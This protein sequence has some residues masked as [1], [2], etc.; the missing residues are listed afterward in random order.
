[1]PPIAGRSIGG[2]NQSFTP[3]FVTNGITITSPTVAISFG[4]LRRQDNCGSTVSEKI[5]LVDPA[6]LIS[7]RGDRVYFSYYPFNLDDLAYNCATGSPSSYMPDN[8]RDDCYQV[9]PADAYF[10]GTLNWINDET[11]DMDDNGD[12]REI[13]ASLRAGLTIWPDYQPQI[14]MPQTMLP[15]ITSVFASGN[16][17][18]GYYFIGAWDPP[19]TLQ[20]ASSLDGPTI[21]TAATTTSS[22]AGQMASLVATPAHSPQSV[23]GTTTGGPRA[24]SAIS[25]IVSGASQG[26][27]LSTS[28]V[29]GGSG[30][31]SLKPDDPTPIT[32]SYTNTDGVSQSSVEQSQAAQVAGSIISAIITTTGDPTD[33]SPNTADTQDPNTD[34]NGNALVITLGSRTMSA[35]RASTVAGAIVLGSNTLQVS[36][37]AQ[38]FNGQYVSAGTAGLVVGTGTSASTYAISGKDAPHVS[39]LTLDGNIIYIS[40]FTAPDVGVVIGLQTSIPS[41]AMTTGRSQPSATVDSGTSPASADA[42]ASY[43]IAG[44][45]SDVAQASFG[46]TGSGDLDLPLAAAVTIN[47]QVYTML[48]GTVAGDYFLQGPS[49]TITLHR[50]QDVTLSSQLLTLPSY[51]SEAPGSIPY[52]TGSVSSSTLDDQLTVIAL[53]GSGY[54]VQDASTT[55]VLSVGGSVATLASGEVVSAESGGVVLGSIGSQQTIVVGSEGVVF[56]GAS[57]TSDT[58]LLDYSIVRE[59]SGAYVV[60]GPGYTSTMSQGG[61]AVTLNGVGVTA[62]S[63]TLALSSGTRSQTTSATSAKKTSDTTVASSATSAGPGSSAPCSATHAGMAVALSALVTIFLASGM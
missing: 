20:M 18:C 48:S 42:V 60:V 40:S 38:T 4:G 33:Y 29:Y 21:P 52:S 53:T 27:D 6:E 54:A 63:G 47:G 16:E 9:V 5:V 15:W 32:A 26:S 24:G 50:D 17:S 23:V 57:P 22:A 58:P 7:I 25:P 2:Y 44:L 59:S 51:N 8:E 45:G 30:T 49:T 13:P 43:I 56:G 39:S 11:L 37:P 34:S 1:M 41:N 10:D 31:E 55:L 12:L 61:A 35:S 46:F 14:Q 62:A 28:V 19:S 36:D 3:S